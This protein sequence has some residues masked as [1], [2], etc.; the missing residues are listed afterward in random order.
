[1]GDAGGKFAFP[2]LRPGAYLAAAWEE[3]V[4]LPLVR[5]DPRLLK[6]Y[7]EKG[8]A[9]T[10]QPGTPAAAVLTLTS[11]AEVTRARSKP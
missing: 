5:E 8:K 9:V 1:M 4:N 3:M 6:L 11:A 7:R 10:A 2:A